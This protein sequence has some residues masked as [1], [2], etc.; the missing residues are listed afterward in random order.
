MGIIVESKLTNEEILRRTI[1]YILMF[2]L[3]YII[4]EYIPNGSII[5][6]DKLMISFV[7]SCC[8][9]ILDIY[10]PIIKIEK[11]KMITK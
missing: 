2:V 7:I 10:F 4:C 3:T 9:V 1:K 6:G 11:D 5:K 8:L